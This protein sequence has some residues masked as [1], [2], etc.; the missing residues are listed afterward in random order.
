MSGDLTPY[1]RGIADYLNGYAF[2]PDY[3]RWGE[4]TQASYERGR[5]AQ[6]ARNAKKE[7]KRHTLNE[8]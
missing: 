7:R 6:A 8:A 4:E 2:P 5:L 1:Q 3:E